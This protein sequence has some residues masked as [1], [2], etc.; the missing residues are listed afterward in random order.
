M[1][2]N[3]QETT[4]AIAAV[5][6]AP[7]FALQNEM[8]KLSGPPPFFIAICIGSIVLLLLVVYPMEVLELLNRLAEKALIGLIDLSGYILDFLNFLERLIFGKH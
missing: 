3:K 5:E 1:G 7:R 4:V 2:K 6:R 8:P